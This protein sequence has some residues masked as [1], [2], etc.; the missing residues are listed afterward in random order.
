MAEDRYNVTLI[1]KLRVPS[2]IIT[3][4]K[5]VLAV[6]LTINCTPPPA[7]GLL[8]R[9]CC[10]EEFCVLGAADT[11][12][13]DDSFCLAPVDL[14]MKNKW[15]LWCFFGGIL[16][17]MISIVLLVN[18]VAL[19]HK[20]RTPK[21]TTYILL[22]ISNLNTLEKEHEK[23]VA[24]LHAHAVNFTFPLFVSLCLSTGMFLGVVHESLC[25]TLPNA[26]QPCFFILCCK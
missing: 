6:F 17:A 22:H 2:M 21:T 14:C 7:I 11:T 23:N 16:L 25:V 26:D 15:A 8:D 5:N 12:P 24:Y 9:C 20:V 4:I 18:S 13:L 19:H 1:R 3:S 10:A